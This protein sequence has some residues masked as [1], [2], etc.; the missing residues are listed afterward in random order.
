MKVLIYYQYSPNRFVPLLLIWSTALAK[1]LSGTPDPTLVRL[2]RQG[3]SYL[4]P[5]LGSTYGLP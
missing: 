5:Y 4:I 3:G 2:Q 1:T